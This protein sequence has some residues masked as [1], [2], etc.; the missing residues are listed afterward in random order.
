M[1]TFWGDQEELDRAVRSCL[2]RVFL[3]MFAALL[4][5]AASALVVVESA[6]LQEIIFGYQYVFYVLIF[7]NVILVIGISAGINRMPPAMASILFFFYAIMNGITMS[8]IFFYFNIEVIAMAFAIAAAMFAAMAI[9]GATTRRDLSTV[10]SFCMMGLV[11]II[12]ASIANFFLRS[13]LI[14]FIV[15]Y[16]GV[17]IF[18]GLTAYDT[19]RIKTMLMES[20]ATSH[21]DAIKRISIIGALT[22]YLDF[23]NLFLK[24]LRVLGRRR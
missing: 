1:P 16:A 21:Y 19:R 14:D 17:L 12:I 15:C 7:A 3:R 11:G 20:H 13:D 5:T 10:G 9:Y 2:N 24:V 23:I 6:A 8:S 22:L 18:V 4:A